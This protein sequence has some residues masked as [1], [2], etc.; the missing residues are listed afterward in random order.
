MNIIW[1]IPVGILLG[2]AL[3]IVLINRSRRHIGTAWF[4]SILAA[5]FVWGWTISL[6]WQF[7]P[8]SGDAA[9]ASI[10]QSTAAD[11][12]TIIETTLISSANFVLDRI[13]YP[14]MLAVSTLLVI[15]LFTAPSYME[16]Q[17]AP[18]VWF[19]YLLI[20]AIGY[21]TVSANDLT[22]IVYG[23]VI[24]DA[25]DLST[26]YIQQYPKMIKK[27]SL[28]A[29][30]IR[31][32]GTIL[33]YSGLALSSA[34]TDPGSRVFISA[35]AG[36][37]LLLA[38]A[39]RMGILPISQPYSEMS[40][41]RIGLGTMLRLV[42]VLTTIPVL[43][44]I[45]MIEM[46]PNLG[47]FLNIAGIFAS[48][49]GAVGWLLSENSF[50]GNT[51]AALS[52]CGMAY[53]CAVS[54]DQSSLTAWG[55]SI[56]LTCAPLSLYQIR[57]GFM[58]IL[59]IL[60]IICFSG[61]PYTPNAVGWNGLV[62]APY[63]FKDLLFIMIM[64]LLIGGALIHVLRAEGKKFSELEP[65]M[66]SIYPLGFL[67][68]IGIHIFISFFCYT[69]HFNSGVIPASVTA[70]SGGLLL[71]ILVLRLPE[72]LK[73][74][75]VIAWVRE[76]VSFFWRTMERLLNMSWLI[77]FGKRINDGTDRLTQSIS[78]VLEN[79]GGLVWELLLLGFLVAAA[80]SGEMF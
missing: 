40:S 37:W 66:R 76:G 67:A 28:S 47:I 75:N 34:D 73:R 11:P 13:S 38:C 51:Y 60:V 20:E 1:S 62:R 5:L 65:W 19:F 44:R 36:I 72:P 9:A 63:S 18:R 42:S 33:A 59:A 22:F 16:P 30:G 78:G 12:E 49:T 32:I 2:A 43:S 26:Q 39:L 35:G 53:V 68:S 23:W 31:F 45:P 55:I 14:Y 29:V 64:L 58:N 61:L 56:I 79:N 17:T 3:L 27:S 48:L 8:K 70:F 7:D 80:F 21:L 57:N 10:T 41:S 24:F 4:V 15:L 71:A 46:N 77:S 74:R 25:I 69:D 50:R 54:G 6:Y 52:I